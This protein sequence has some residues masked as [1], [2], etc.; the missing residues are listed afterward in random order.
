VEKTQ[1]KWGSENFFFGMILI[2][3]EFPFE[4]HKRSF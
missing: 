1:K 3:V 2:W 4:P